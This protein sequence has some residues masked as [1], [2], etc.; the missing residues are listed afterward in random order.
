[1][2]L[3]HTIGWLML[4]LCGA[5][6]AGTINVTSD[7]GAHNYAALCVLRD[8]IT[9]AN[10]GT[11]TGGCTIAAP[12]PPTVPDSPDCLC[13]ANTIVLPAGATITLTEVDDASVNTG[14]PSIT[15]SLTITG[16]G[17]TVRRDPALGCNQDGI[18][19]AGEF[20][21]I[22]NAS[23]LL[24]LDHLTLSN[25]CADSA[26]YPF[27]KG[28]AISSNSSLVLQ[29][30][31]LGDNYAS[32]R[33]GA[34]YDNGFGDGAGYV[35]ITDST[36]SGNVAMIGG[37]IFLEGSS[38]TLTVQR[39]LFVQNSASRNAG[40]AIYIGLASTAMVIN[41][42][43]S[44]NDA[45]SGGAIEA[46]GIVAVSNSTLAQN[47]TTYGAALQIETNGAGQQTTVK[48]SLFAANTGETGNCAFAS[49]AVT[50]AGMNLSDDASCPGVALSGTDAKLLPLKDNGG[51]TLT[52]GLQTTSPAVDAQLDCTDSGGFPIA[53]DQRG[54]VRPVEIVAAAA[55][56]DIGA[57]ELGDEVFH[58]G[59]DGQAAN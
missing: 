51:P 26:D 30:V 57:F 58:D 15:G 48:N 18:N 32:N 29:H 14:L 43:F 17:S 36:I 2:N 37:G 4:A 39:S 20:A 52:Y 24:V 13:T 9:T 27:A 11:A 42:T 59:F 45:G 35:T 25:G 16:N 47:A 6:G 54:F 1:M 31:V 49:G 10:T 55:L 3:Q 38:A 19:D 53:T 28:G 23:P 12:P 7:L 5:A 8:A 46:D 40:G 33:G 21:L 34:I 50:M 41:S 22:Y 44:Q 56:C